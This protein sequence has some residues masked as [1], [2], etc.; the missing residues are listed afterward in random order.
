MVVSIAKPWT[1]FGKLNGGIAEG[2]ASL[3]AALPSLLINMPLS[4]IFQ[5]DASF[6][7]FQLSEPS[8]WY[9]TIPRVFPGDDTGILPPALFV[10]VPFPICMPRKRVPTSKI[11]REVEAIILITMRCLGEEGYAPT[12]GI[13]SSITLSTLEAKTWK[14]ISVSAVPVNIYQ[15]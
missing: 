12:A 5:S 7:P 3:L 13:I 2:P 15:H 14:V 9:K 6:Q 1:P 4:T 8:S 11:T 10:S